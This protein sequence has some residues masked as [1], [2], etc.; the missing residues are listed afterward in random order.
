MII[1]KAEIKFIYSFIHSDYN[2]FYGFLPLS[3]RDSQKKKNGERGRARGL[4]AANDPGW[5]QTC[6]AAV[7]T[8][9]QDTVHALDEL[10]GHFS[11]LFV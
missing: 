4:H 5:N 1:L 11:L 7:K 3:D 6:T 10:L 2:F 9:P 8:H